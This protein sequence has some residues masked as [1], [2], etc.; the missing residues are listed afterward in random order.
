MSAYKLSF[1]ML[2]GFVRIVK[3]V[4]L[5][6][7]KLTKMK[8]WTCR[9]SLFSHRLFCSVKAACKELIHGVSWYG[10]FVIEEISSAFFSRPIV[11]SF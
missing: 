10:F 2:L 6:E 9:A 4:H 3:A 8:F 1:I 11:Y 5:F 7:S